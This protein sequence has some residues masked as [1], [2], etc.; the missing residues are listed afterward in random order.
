MQEAAKGAPGRRVGRQRLKAVDRDHA[1]PTVGDQRPNMSENTVQAAVVER[2]PQ[3]VE[4]HARPDRL[5]VEEVKALPVAQNL[6]ERF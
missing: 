3:V 5:G 4:E 2:L 1:W 6:L